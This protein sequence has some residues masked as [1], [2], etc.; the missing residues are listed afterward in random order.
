[1]HMSREHHLFISP[2]L[3]SAIRS[4][5][6]CFLNEYWQNKFESVDDEIRS[7]YPALV[8]DFNKTCEEVRLKHPV[9]VPVLYKI[10]DGL[11]TTADFVTMREACVPTEWLVRFL[12]VWKQVSEKRQGGETLVSFIQ[13]VIDK[14]G[15]IYILLI[16]ATGE[17]HEWAQLACMSSLLLRL[18]TLSD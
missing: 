5:Q 12:S 1:M 8:E 9:L 2:E 3:R 6:A 10:L 17:H 7:K 18:K 15:N 13:G 11:G 14:V 16:D 4:L